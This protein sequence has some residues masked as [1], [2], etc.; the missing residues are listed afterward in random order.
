MARK[1]RN[2]P[3]KLL[4]SLRFEGT[5]QGRADLWQMV[6]EGWRHRAYIVTERRLMQ[7]DQHHFTPCP[8]GHYSIIVHVHRK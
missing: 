4:Q 8:D 2:R 6:A 1:A 5:A 7:A 3:G